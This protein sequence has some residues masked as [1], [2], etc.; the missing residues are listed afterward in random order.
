MLV[1]A[2]VGVPVMAPVAAFNESPTGKLPAETL[3]VYEPVP[4]VALA[5]LRV[6]N[7]T[8]PFG[9]VAG[10]TVIAA[11]IVTAYAC[12]PVAPNPSVAVI[13]KL[14]LRRSW[15]TRYRTGAALSDKPVGKLPAETL[16]V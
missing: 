5:V 8:V 13:V 7:P 14:M 3:N 15:S 2:V 12:E 10:L 11:L 16:N 4:P 1:A 9:N 6:G